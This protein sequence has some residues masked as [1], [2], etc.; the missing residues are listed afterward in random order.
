MLLPSMHLT[1]VGLAALG[2][3]L[4]QYIDTSSGYFAPNS[5]GFRIQHGFESVLV[6]P[7]GYDGFRVRAWPFRPPNGNEISFFVDP[8]E[9]GPGNSTSLGMTYDVK[10]NGTQFA[11][12]RNGNTIVKTFSPNQNNHTLVR[13]AFYRLEEDGSET[14]LL[15]EYSPLKSLNSRYYSWN[16]PGFEF[17]A[18]FSFATTPDEQIYGTGRAAFCRDHR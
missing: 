13:L 1:I 9:E 17:E 2:T 12:I 4:A 10:V 18:A 7:F 14:L 11:A 3:A 8:P 15:N 6:Q 16:G 5:T